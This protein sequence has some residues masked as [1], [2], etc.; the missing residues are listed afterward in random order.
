MFAGFF[1]GGVDEN[2]MLLSM[3]AFEEAASVVFTSTRISWC[4]NAVRFRPRG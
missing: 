2:V 4:S 1:Q 3:D